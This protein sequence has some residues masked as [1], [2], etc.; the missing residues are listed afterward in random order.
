MNIET[1]NVDLIDDSG[2]LR[3]VNLEYVAEMAHSVMA[4]KGIMTP[5]EVRKELVGGRYRLV[6]GAHRLAA[7][8]A[9]GKKTVPVVF[10]EGTDKEARLREI[11]EN[12]IRNEL[13]TLDRAKFVAERISL[14]GDHSDI[15][16]SE[17]SSLKSDVAEKLGFSKRWVEKLVGLNAMMDELPSDLRA[18]IAVSTLANKYQELV[19]IAAIEDIDDRRAVIDRLLP[20]EGEPSFST[21]SAALSD[22]RGSLPEHVDADQK[23]LDDFKVRWAKASPNARALI[24]EYVAREMKPRTPRARAQ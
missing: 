23:T 3:D 22:V 7:A 16:R 5:I 18:R 6:A 19:A 15:G 17:R 1:I 2:R 12:L 4:R 21:V 9:A 14:Q 11:D 10:F 24:A 8:K 20:P 13:S